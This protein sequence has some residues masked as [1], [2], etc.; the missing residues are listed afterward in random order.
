MRRLPVL[1]F[2]HLAFYDLRFL[3]DFR[4]FCVLAGDNGGAEIRIGGIVLLN[5]AAQ[6]FAAGLEE[7]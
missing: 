6:V 3:G 2:A 7:G 1:R 5:R 4:W